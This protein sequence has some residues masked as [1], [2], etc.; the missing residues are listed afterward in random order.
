[1]KWR[2]DVNHLAKKTWLLM[3]LLL[4]SLSACGGGSASVT[5]TVNSVPIFTQIASTALALQT[6]TA[7]AMP[8][9]T[10]TPQVSPTP[11]TTNTPL[12]TATSL[13][14]TVPAS[15]P[16]SATPLSKNTPLATAQVSCDNMAYVAD[17]T[18]PDGSVAAPG[19][20]MKK[21][22]TVKNIGPC[23]WNQDYKLIFGWGGQGT[24]WS[25]LQPVALSKDVAPGETISITV[26]LS[27]PSA[28]GEYVAAFKLQNDKGINFPP[29][30][31]LT[32]DIVVK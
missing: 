3:A 13:A 12:I 28:S 1:M 29:G 24:D 20:V 16:A 22:W 5:P 21:T 19:E 9:A 14:G 17:V 25:T 7:L 15:T 23:P 11:K 26:E 8:T 10:S 4:V 27:A 18:I 31:Q 32:I 30:Q 2:F 6:Q